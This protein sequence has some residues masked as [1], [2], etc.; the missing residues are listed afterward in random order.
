MPVLL[1]YPPV[2]KPCEPPPGIARLM[3]SLNRHGVEATAI[4]ANLEALI[5]AAA[6]VSSAND[7]WTRRAIRGLDANLAFLRDQAACRNPDRYK[8]AVHDI[9]RL[10]GP[11][12]AQTSASDWPNIRTD[13]FPRFEAPI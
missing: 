7:T 12:P 4:D 9:Q 6:S 5:F 3:A 1:I 10:L 2:A 11:V 8:R 13:P